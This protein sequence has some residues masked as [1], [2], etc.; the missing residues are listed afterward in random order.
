[1]FLRRREARNALPPLE[2]LV[3]YLEAAHGEVIHVLVR[4]GQSDLSVSLLL[5]IN[6]SCHL[7]LKPRRIPPRENISDNPEIPYGLQAVKI[8]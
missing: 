5:L 7:I 3:M 6:R 2:Y 8:G 4:K 1:M